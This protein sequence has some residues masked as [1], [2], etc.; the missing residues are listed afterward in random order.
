[1]R[2]VSED[3][4]HESMSRFLLEEKK[5]W[6]ISRLLASAGFLDNII[7]IFNGD[8]DI[9][10]LYGYLVK[11]DLDVDRLDYLQRDSLHTGVAYGSVDVERILRTVTVDDVAD[12]SFLV[13]MEKGT[14]AIENYVLAR[15]HMYNTVYYHKSVIAFELML[16]RLYELLAD[17]SIARLPTLDNVRNMTQEQF[18]T[19]DDA[20]VFGAFDQYLR[21]NK[22]DTATELIRMI[23]SRTPVKEAYH[24]LA[25][26]EVSTMKFDELREDIATKVRDKLASESGVD[27]EWI[28]VSEPEVK[29]VEDNDEEAI[30]VRHDSG[31][32]K[33]ADDERSI[34]HRLKRLRRRGFRVF[35]KKELLPK[36]EE[37]IKNFGKR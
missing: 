22:A 34:V 26:T 31:Y 28:F 3:G 10:A 33:I 14:Q 12:P 19:Y 24:D 17:P 20:H 27:K 8:L 4:K 21:A 7:K 36:L 1:M 2:R 11:S 23:Y 13:V 35:T 15:Y 37:P 16:D 32:G 6:P 18:A 5:D 29:I 9:P 25:I 30:Y